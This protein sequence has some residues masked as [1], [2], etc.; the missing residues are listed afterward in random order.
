[1]ITGDR[2][3]VL[4]AG[5]CVVLLSLISPWV[6]ASVDIA[7]LPACNTYI[8]DN[9]PNLTPDL[10][11][12][13]KIHAAFLGQSQEARMDGVIAYI[14]NISSGT[15]TSTLQDIENDYLAV[16]SSIP[17]MTTDDEISSARNEMRE[18]TQLFSDETNARLGLYNGSTIEMRA[19]IDSYELA[20]DASFRN[21]NASL[22]LARDSAR[23]VQFDAESEQRAQFLTSLDRQGVNTSAALNISDQIDAQRSAVQEALSNNSVEALMT[24]NAGIQVLNRQFRAAVAGSQTATAIEAE[25]EALMAMQNRAP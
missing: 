9:S 3:A 4:I 24:A 19:S 14:G 10:V 17:L 18:Q 25:R 7:S 2:K 12:A 16:A 22:W 8:T 6:S 21:I 20:A 15:G 5:L 11:P 1:M 23:L 13:L